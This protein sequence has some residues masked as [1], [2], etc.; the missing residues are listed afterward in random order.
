M[1]PC[2]V[3]SLIALAFVA[4]TLSPARAQA[5]APTRVT[6]ARNPF[7][8]DQKAITPAGGAVFTFALPD[9]R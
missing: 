3:Q 8:G 7:T 6:A 5:P 2:R 1:R 9:N 4:A